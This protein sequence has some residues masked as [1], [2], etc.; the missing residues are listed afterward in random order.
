MKINYAIAA[1]LGCASIC[2]LQ[3]QTK[4]DIR[5]Q[6]Q[7]ITQYN[8]APTR[9]TT[10][11]RDTQARAAGLF[12]TIITLADAG[13]LDELTA[14]GITADAVVGRRVVAQVTPAQLDMLQQLDCVELISLAR[15]L[16]ADNNLM[17]Q[18]S[19]I[20]AVRAGDGLDRGYD[21]TGV[22]VGLFDSGMQPNNI[23]F[24][25]PDGSSR[26]KCLYKYEMAQDNQ[27]NTS[28]RETAYTTPGKIASFT[29]EDPDGTHG[30]HVLGIAAG[31][32]TGGDEDYSGVAPGSDIAIACGWT[33]DAAIITGVSRLIAYAESATRPIVINLSL[34]DIMGPH[35]GT[36]PFT[37]TIDELA[38]EHP[39]FISAGN[40]GDLGRALTKQLDEAGDNRMR[41]TLAGNE[42]LAI[43]NKGLRGQKWDAQGSYEIYASDNR[44]FK[45]EVGIVDKT[46][47]EMLYTVPVAE[48][49]AV[50]ATSTAGIQGQTYSEFL[51]Q[52]YTN[53]YI[54]VITGVAENDRYLASINLS[55]LKK[56]PFNNNIMPAIV[57]TGA[58]GRQRV[59]LHTDS[60]CNIFA[61]SGLEGWDDATTD[62]SNNNLTCG[63][64]VIGV[65][66]Y[67]TRIV[68]PYE[69][70][71][72]GTVAP[73][74]G[75]ST[76]VDGTVRPHVCA[77]GHALISSMSSYFRESRAYSATQ[78]PIADEVTADGMT[79]YWVPMSGTSM[80]APV[81]TGTAALWLQANPELTPAEI[82][83]IAIKTA[84]VPAEPS[85]RWGA[86]RID[87]L[88]GI[89]LAIDMNSVADVM[90]DAPKTLIQRDGDLCR[91]LVPGTDTFDVEVYNM[92]GIS[93]TTVQ[94]TAG[95][96]TVDL[97]SLAPGIY[98]IR[99]AGA[100][101]RIIR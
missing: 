45:L 100:T 52:Y 69:F 34:G 24:R 35:D 97:S 66:A 58:G 31:S 78:F 38:A 61:A 48:E 56:A 57:I 67:T 25:N 46:T 77:P 80:A 76:L 93:V 42:T 51:N 59:D 74:S 15:K 29:T 83:N 9:I 98:I 89:K 96:A 73:F 10:L 99:A 7:L 53:S 27:G 68:A 19:N 90:A 3:A 75:S 1:L 36:D 11:A 30:T 72:L 4:F 55:L 12:R 71:E 63:K 92:S 14:A 81:A 70:G 16:K 37:A 85:A 5:S 82:K 101:R 88:A 62:G 65:G 8:V 13:D 33:D 18:A 86:G 20:D 40:S 79:Y 41:T 84:Q 49:G 23:N 17:R 21:G 91:I 64:N 22:I 44:P 95:E 47:G 6:Q 60:T 32:Y 54:S 43:L 50:Y 94:G 28:V 87:A 39:F 2:T 26:V